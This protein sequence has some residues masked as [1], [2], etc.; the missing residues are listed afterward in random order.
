MQSSVGQN[1]EVVHTAVDDNG[2]IANKDP[3][4]RS[5]LVRPNEHPAPIIKR[6]TRTLY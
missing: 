1:R 2:V 6:A 4:K 5:T 3:P